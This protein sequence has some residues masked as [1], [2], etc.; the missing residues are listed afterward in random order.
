[1]LQQNNSLLLWSQTPIIYISAKPLNV[2][3][4]ASYKKLMT[5]SAQSC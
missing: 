5:E 2:E 3:A 1:M 4:Y